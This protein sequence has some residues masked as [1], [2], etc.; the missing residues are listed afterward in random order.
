MSGLQMIDGA[1]PQL[2]KTSIGNGRESQGEKSMLRGVNSV[3]LVVTFVL[4]SHTPVGGQGR[5]ES[6]DRP[7]RGRELAR[8]GYFLDAM[9]WEP[10]FPFQSVTLK[11][12]GPEGFYFE[13][14]FSSNDSV[15]FDVTGRLLDGVYSYE[16]VLTP[17]LTDEIREELANTRESRKSASLLRSLREEGLLPPEAQSGYFTIKD[18]VVLDPELEEAEY[19]A[20]FNYSRIDPGVPD[21]TPKSDQVILDDLIV[22]GSICVGEDCVNG[23]SF[24]YDTL[25]LKENNLRI[26]FQD[27]SNSASFPTNDWQITAND[28]ENGGAE[29]FSIDDIDGGRTPFTIEAG[30]PSHSL[31]VDD[32]GRLGLGTST[33]VVQVHVVDGNTPTLRLEQDGSSGFTPQ[34][35]DVAGNEANFFIRDATNGS[36]LPFRIYPGADSNS[37]TIASD[38]DVGLGLN[39][40]S[41]ALH[42]KRTDGTSQ[43]L[44]EEASSTTS[45]RTLLHLLNKG[46][47]RFTMQNAATNKFW[48]FTGYDN[49]FTIAHSTGNTGAEFRLI[50]NSGDLEI[51]GEV[52]AA[53][54]V[55]T[56]DRNLKEGFTVI[57]SQQVLD[58]VASL[59]I[60]EW[61]YKADEADTR[62]LGP[63]AQ[64]F[65]SAFGLGKDDR[66]INAMD[67]VGISLAAIQGLYERLEQKEAEIEHLKAELAELENLRSEL[68]EI[69]AMLQR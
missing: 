45:A 5:P 7:A 9:A 40:A 35:W 31:Y 6:T 18:G 63:V 21:L 42:V 44:V 33:P 22:D 67:G 15:Y 57:D 65:R 54:F 14:T 39:N 23:E 41:A 30:S 66:H 19:G 60:T 27:T 10:E 46:R 24:G 53:D 37:I 38:N 16:L 52:H 29:K 12:A 13:K 69:K 47:I 62:H 26:K 25:R 8:V 2:R 36:T 28:S 56:S 17:I 59:P 3:L 55:V 1:G 64:D 20:G 34:T 43:I 48:S 61:E 51:K 68:A 32:G 4:F 58:K 49:S 11:V 50:P